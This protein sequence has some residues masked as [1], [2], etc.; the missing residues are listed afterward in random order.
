MKHLLVTYT[1]NKGNLCI[2]GFEKLF[3]LVMLVNQNYNREF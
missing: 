1:L 2:L 3:T